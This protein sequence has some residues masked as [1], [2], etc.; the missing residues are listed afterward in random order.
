MADHLQHGTFS[1]NELLTTDVDG[2]KR[3]Y[4][5]LFGWQFDEVN[6]AGFPYYLAKLDGGERAGIMAV[7][8]SAQGAPPHWGSYV[9]VD[10]VD[11]TAAK[12]VELGGQVCV[13]PMDIPGVGRFAI[14][15]DPQGANI[16]VITYVPCPGD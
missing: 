13:P 12:V 9:T 3:F 15:T 4:G 16:G 2:A 5:A 7:P 6:P 14:V 11:A 10:D 1:W 8:P